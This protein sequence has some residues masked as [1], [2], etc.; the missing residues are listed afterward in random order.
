M[1]EQQRD[2]LSF[3]MGRPEFLRFLYRHAIQNGRLFDHDPISPHGRDLA[4]ATGRRGLALDML[5]EADA[6]QSV[7][8]PDGIP[9]IATIQ[10]LRE[11]AQSTQPEKPNDRYDRRRELGDDDEPGDA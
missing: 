8:S 6:A 3:L 10:I 2:D 11:T 9:L 7:Q 1:N 4:E 5:R